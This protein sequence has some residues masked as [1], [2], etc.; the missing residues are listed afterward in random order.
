MFRWLAVLILLAGGT[1]ALFAIVMPKWDDPKAPDNNGSPP[2]VAPGRDD[3]AT[4][5]PKAPTPRPATDFTPPD[6]DRQLP[7]PTVFK[8]DKATYLDQPLTIPSMLAPFQQQEVPC[9]KEGKVLFIGIEVK[10]GEVVPPEDQLPQ[11]WFGFLVVQAEPNYKGPF[12]NIEG[13]KPS[14]KYRAWRERDTVEPGKCIAVV[15]RGRRFRKLREGMDVQA[16]ELVALVNPAVA[17]SEL[18][19]SVGELDAAHAE[20]L[21]AGKAKEATSYRYH[22]YL[23]A[24]LEHPGSISDEDFNKAKLEY[25]KAVEDEKK[26]AANIRVAQNKLNKAATTLK[27]HEIRADISGCV[28]TINRNVQGE[29]VKPLDP[30]LTIQ[31]IKRLKVDGRLELQEALKLIDPKTFKVRE[32]MK[33]LIDA[34]RPEPPRGV[35]SG[36]RAPVTCVAVAGGKDPVIISGSEDLTLRG[37]DPLTRRQLWQLDLFSVPTAVAC[38]PDGSLALFGDKAGMLRLLDLKTLQ[39]PQELKDRHEGEVLSVAFSPDGHTCASGGV[40]LSL[41]LWDAQTRKQLHCVKPAHRNHVTAVQFAGPDRVVT[42]GRDHKLEFWD[43]KDGRRPKQLLPDAPKNRTGDVTC[44]GV[45]PDGKL[46]LSDQGHE[47]VLLSLDDLSKE[48]VLSNASDAQTFTGMA[49]FA[50]DGETILTNTA[51]AGRL[52]LWRAPI[53]GRRPAEIRQFIWTGG[54]TCAAFAPKADAKGDPAA[55]LRHFAVTGTTD[56]QVLIWALPSDEE[57]DSEWFQLTDRSFAALRDA[58]VSDDV[59]GR[60]EPLKDKK[61]ATRDPFVAELAKA[62]DKDTFA[63]C[64]DLVVYHAIGSSLDVKLSLVDPRLETAS[65]QVRIRAE[66]NNPGFLIPGAPVS[67]VVPP[68][69]TPLTKR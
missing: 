28:T 64:R 57:V 27:M 16:G 56:H 3:N 20:W 39:E 60:L 53:E 2:A 51:G 23:K 42:A 48:G 44:P 45:S 22:A 10:D 4:D 15:D 1:V 13:V 65:R 47:L 31:D 18:Q 5:R 11:P 66:L 55:A 41:C 25:D 38:S 17:F 37:W 24:R 8:A 26:G 59:R 7:A 52:Q 40:D 54:T 33:V 32:G 61:F 29:A 19:V 46:V 12:V 50:P 6:W 67:V 14:V 21:A 69:P 43:V 68:E 30:L 58:G 35:L 49:L 36:H 63:R 62:L 34:S 9:E